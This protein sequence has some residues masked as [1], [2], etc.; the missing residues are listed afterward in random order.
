MNRQCARREVRT[1]ARVQAEVGV[2]DLDSGGVRVDIDVPLLRSV[3]SAVSSVI[4][5]MSL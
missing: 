3:A 4:I 2:G 5:R 1:I